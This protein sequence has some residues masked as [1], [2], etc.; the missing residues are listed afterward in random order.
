M[1][2]L[3]SVLRESDDLSSLPKDIM[4]D[5]RRNIR[6]GAQDLSQK[7]ANALELVHR[8]YQVEGIERPKPQMKDA[9]EQYQENIKY[10]VDQLAQNRGMDGDWRMSSAMFRD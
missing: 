10:A 1:R 3:R 6:D 4:S 9:W 8:A 2:F 5:I 7:W